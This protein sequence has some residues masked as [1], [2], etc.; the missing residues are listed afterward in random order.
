MADR[1]RVHLLENLQPFCV[2]EAEQEDI[3][4]ILF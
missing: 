1:V 4:V 3:S 2:S